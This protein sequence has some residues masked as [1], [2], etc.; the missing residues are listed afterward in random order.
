ML[1]MWKTSNYDLQY[2]K[3]VSADINS[4]N[5]RRALVQSHLLDEASLNQLSTET[6]LLE[7]LVPI[8]WEN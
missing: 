8:L 2:A 7:L 3:P 4:T 6:A 5:L 1:E